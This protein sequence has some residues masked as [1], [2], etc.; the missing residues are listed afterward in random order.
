M[1]VE[2]ERDIFAEKLRNRMY[3]RATS[4]RIPFII[5]AAAHGDFG[6]FLKDAIPA[7]RSGADFIADGMY[8]SVTCAEDTA[9]IDEAEA[10]RLNAGN[11]FG[12]YRVEQQVRACQLWP[13]GK[14]P[15]GYHDLIASDI[16]VLL[17]SGNLDPVTPPSLGEKVASHL[18][19]HH[20]PGRRAHLGRAHASRVPR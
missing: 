13:R 16:P 11:R 14:I 17:F 6:P 20:R 1:T 18:P 5:H 15:A 8:L 19:A 10:V 9:F 4:R 2:I 12:N 3:S 7:D